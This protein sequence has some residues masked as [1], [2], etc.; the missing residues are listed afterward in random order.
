MLKAL[1]WDVDGT[2]AETERDG[3]RL[4]FNQ[5]F[6]ECGLPWHWGVAEYG[7]LLRVA[8]GFERLLAYM[9]ERTD[10]AAGSDARRRLA[11]EIHRSKNRH[12]AN[13]VAQGALVARPGVMRLLGEC[14][15]QGIAQAVATT[16]SRS[17]V[18]ALFPHLFGASWQ[19]LF[20]A[21]V[22]AEDA[23]R[24]KPDPQVYR[25]A[26]ERLGCTPATVI[27]IEDSPAGLAAARAAG[28]AC[29][30]TPS[31][32]FAAAN[33]S[34]AVGVCRDLDAGPVDVAA[35]QAS[36]ARTWDP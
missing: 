3:H 32:Y 17:N 9:D 12:Y 10:L 18:E 35:L 6:A 1:I 34:A 4:A 25:L 7:G 30:V 15:E 28:V 20:A 16:T 27:A 26:L 23:P 29:L 21:V 24:K 36:L 22:C 31:S 2:L 5:A 33:F 11:G 13:L 19:S 14:R 8:G